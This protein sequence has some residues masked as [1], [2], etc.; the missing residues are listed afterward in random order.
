MKKR[1]TSVALLLL[2][3][4]AFPALADTIYLPS[5]LRNLA[6]PPVTH[7]A[8]IGNSIAQHVPAPTIGWY[9]YWGMAATSIEKDYVHR[10]GDIIATEYRVLPETKVIRGTMKSL[11]LTTPEFTE[12]VADFDPELIIVQLSDNLPEAIA[13]RE[14]FYDPYHSLLL[15][16]TAIS[17]AP[18][19]CVG[20]WSTQ[21]AIRDGFIAEAAAAVGATFVA[22]TDLSAV[23][24]NRAISQGECTNVNV[25]WHPSDAGMERIAERVILALDYAA[26]MTGGVE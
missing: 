15:G 9:G 20:T 1:I 24:E 14:T 23:Y 7:I 11:A 21:S 13:S 2:A 19:I 10:L 5:L 12:Q 4:L 22:I 6:P 18:I 25:C 8:V 3:L 26:A 17:D 16:L